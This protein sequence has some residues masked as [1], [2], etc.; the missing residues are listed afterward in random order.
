MPPELLTVERTL[1]ERVVRQIVRQFQPD[2]VILFGSQ[3]YG[4]PNADSDVDLL[5]VLETTEPPGRCAARV[6]A[7]VDHPFPLDIIVRT[8]GALADAYRRGATFATEVLTR[9]VVLYEAGDRGVAAQGG[10]RPESR[11]A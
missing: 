11:P 6:A 10:E 2:R 4:T 1:L 7:A 5:V 9:G 3:A 8:P